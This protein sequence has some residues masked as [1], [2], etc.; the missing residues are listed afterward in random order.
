MTWKLNEI[1]TSSQC[2]EAYVD[3]YSSLFISVRFGEID[4][5]KHMYCRSPS[6]KKMNRHVKEQNVHGCLRLCNR[7]SWYNYALMDACVSVWTYICH[8]TIGIPKHAQ[9]VRGKYL[10]SSWYITLHIPEIAAKVGSWWMLLVEACYFQWKL[11]A[12]HFVP[13]LL[14][15]KFHHLFQ[16]CCHCCRKLWHSL[17]LLRKHHGVGHHNSQPVQLPAVQFPTESRPRVT[18]TNRVLTLV[19][20]MFQNLLG[21]RAERWWLGLGSPKLGALICDC[22]WVQL[23]CED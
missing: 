6:T 11:I 2:P 19:S 13:I 1:D 4:W 10:L 7:S 8:Y 5:Y 3:T 21:V 16:I 22:Q 12:F 23:N 18:C 15:P 17:F 9:D 20:Q 14:H